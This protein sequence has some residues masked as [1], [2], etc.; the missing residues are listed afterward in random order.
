MSFSFASDQLGAR[1]TSNGGSNSFACKGL[2]YT[3]KG[4]ACLL[5]A[6][7][8]VAGTCKRVKPS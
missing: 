5:V 4:S 7:R 1:G 8:L 6:M 2:F 3:G